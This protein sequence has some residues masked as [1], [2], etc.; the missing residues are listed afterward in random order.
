MHLT[1]LLPQRRRPHRTGGAATGVGGTL[2][3]CALMVGTGVLPTMPAEAARPNV[4]FISIDDLNDWIEPFNDPAR[5]KPKIA[6]PNLRELAN[7]GVAFTNAH[8]PIPLCKPTRASIMAGLYPRNNRSTIRHYRND[9]HEFTGI[10]TLTQHFRRHGYLTLGAG[11]IYPPLRRPERHWD[12]FERFKRPPNQKRNPAVLLN[13]LADM[14]PKDPFDWGAV[15]YEHLAMSDVR[16]AEWAIRA[17]GKDYD[18]PFFLGLGFHFPHLP[19]YLPRAHL[20]RYPLE[21]IVL[22]VV[23]EDDLD[24]VPPEGKKVA[25]WTPRTRTSHYEGSDHR[26]V[27]DA[28]AWKSAVQAYSAASTF[29]DDQLGRVLEA[30]GSSAHADN[31]IVVVFADNG[32]HLGE[33]QRWRKMA[34]WEESTRVP[35][36]VSYPKALPS[37]REVDTA[38][39]L[40]DLYPTLLEMTSLPAPDHALDGRSLLRTLDGGDA[41]GQRFALSVWGR[42]NVAIRDDRWRYIRYTKGGEE[43]YDHAGDPMEHV[44]L[45]A[46]PDAGQHAERVAAFNR[47]IDRYHPRETGGGQ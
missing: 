39:S 35:L 34:L 31:T 29:V 42:G 22:P 28:G 30:L 27:L 21:S 4:L 45:L 12:V 6:G 24:D 15:E 37:G 40:V 8:T 38:V 17:L 1:R 10:T 47:I 25:W 23:R 33:K 32:W 46:L 20:E 14:H 11:K 41:G 18:Q 36:V 3:S 19:W 44:N 43:L 13:G 16:I 2:L 7:R 26:K 5:G 9:T